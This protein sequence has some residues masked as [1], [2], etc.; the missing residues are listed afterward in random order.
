MVGM[1]GEGNSNVLSSLLTVTAGD[2]IHVSGVETESPHG[3]GNVE[4]VKIWRIKERIELVR[5]QQQ[6]KLNW[7]C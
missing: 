4:M 5:S 6:E 7:P 3:E 1:G 2:A